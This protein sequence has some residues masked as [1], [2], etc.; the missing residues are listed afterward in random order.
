MRLSPYSSVEIVHSAKVA[1]G[2]MRGLLAQERQRANRYKSSTFGAGR[3]RGG[4]VPSLYVLLEA[5]LAD[6][7]AVHS[8][9]FGINLVVNI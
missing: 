4:K 8:S 3:G 2:S 9:F 7:Y 6:G 1:H 5:I